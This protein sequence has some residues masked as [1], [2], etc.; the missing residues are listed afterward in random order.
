[1]D[2]ITYKRSSIYAKGRCCLVL[3][4]F[5]SSCAINIPVINE[6]KQRFCV[7]GGGGTGDKYQQRTADTMESVGCTQ[8]IVTG[9]LVYEYGI[10]S[11]DDKQVS[12][13][14]LRPYKKLLDK[15][16]PFYLSMGVN[17]WLLLGSGEYWISISEQNK[18][19][20]Y[21]NYNYMARIGKVCLFEFDSYKNIKTEFKKEGCELK[22]GFSYS[23]GRDD[24]V[25]D[26]DVYI[27]GDKHY[28]AD[29]GV[30]RG[31]RLLISGSASKLRELKGVPHVWG[32]SERGLL[33][34]DYPSLEFYFINNDKK[35]IHKD[36]LR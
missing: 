2:R 32:A 11:V 13:K 31:S 16:V 1:M 3:L 35:I 22:I 36:Q 8:V 27:T 9:G 5:I 23:L 17:D 19:I 33:V 21:P 7:I 30:Y 24:G 25:D 34:I 12:D 20:V 10:T 29:D 28:L 26:Y 18:N 6:F 4:F 15:D 14:F